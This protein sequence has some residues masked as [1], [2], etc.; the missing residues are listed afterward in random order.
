MTAWML[1]VFLL[2]TGCFLLDTEGYP[3]GQVGESCQSM[4]PNHNGTMPQSSPS[5]FN[6]TASKSWFHPGEEITVTL[7]AENGTSF[8]GFLLQ[9]RTV[10]TNM[11]SGSFKILNA[12]TSQGLT[13]N[14]SNDTVS[15]TSSLQKQSINVV[16]VAPVSGQMEDIEFRSTF[17]EYEYK[18]WVG[19]KSNTITPANGTENSSSTAQPDNH[20]ASP[21]AAEGDSY[22]HVSTTAAEGDSYSHVSTTAA[23]GDSHSQVSQPADGST[24]GSTP[25]N[26][27]HGNWA[28]PSTTVFPV[29]VVLTAAGATRITTTASLS[30]GTGTAVLIFAAIFCPTSLFPGM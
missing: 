2:V 30:A 3:D 23:G 16:W 12:N 20:S 11:T 7:E 25:Q 5:P 28:S 21:T 9:A 15:H 18:F 19:V 10:G 1:S 22:S 13:C 29:L 17:V 4:M 27:G 8:R 14:I 26:S 24:V 6:V